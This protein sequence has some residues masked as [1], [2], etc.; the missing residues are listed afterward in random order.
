MQNFWNTV[1]KYPVF[2]A[3]VILGVLLNAV[4]PLA[5]LMQRPTTAIA[6]IGG[7]V[8]GILFIG[9]TLR[10]MLGFSAV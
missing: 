1:S 4:K 9:L 2:I 8:A 3:G 10:A 5:P 7:A 6:L